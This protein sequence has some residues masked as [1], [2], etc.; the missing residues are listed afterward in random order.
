MGTYHVLASC[1]LLYVSLTCNLMQNYYKNK[2]SKK[3]L[4]KK[5]KKN[6][7]FEVPIVTQRPRFSGH[8]STFYARLS[9]IAA[10]V[11]NLTLD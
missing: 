7:Q 8:L 2:K 11:D 1:M 6:G 4:K 10:V 5:Q 9:T 3:N